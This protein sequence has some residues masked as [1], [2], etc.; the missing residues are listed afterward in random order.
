MKDLTQN[1][2]VL[3]TLERGRQLT[4]NDAG[5]L[6]GIARLARC[7]ND[8]KNEGYNVRKVMIAVRNRRGQCVK[9][10]KYFLRGKQPI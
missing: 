7:V 1:A 8:L 10:A 9:V 4:Q 3:Q 6:Y 2:W 5:R